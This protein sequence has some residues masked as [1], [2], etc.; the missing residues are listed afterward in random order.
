MPSK[1]L[2]KHL[3]TQVVFFT[4]SSNTHWFNTHPEELC[5]CHRDNDSICCPVFAAFCELCL[6]RH[7]SSPL[8][9]L[10]FN[11][12]KLSCLWVIEPEK[13]LVSQA[14]SCWLF[15]PRADA[16]IA[17]RTALTDSEKN[18][19]ISAE[20][21]LMK[22]APKLNVT[23]SQNL[24]DDF[25][26]THIVQANV[27]HNSGPFLPWHRLYSRAPHHSLPILANPGCCSARA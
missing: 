2:I 9:G 14:L 26:Y 7:R 1:D 5:S 18:A 20:L 4:D 17:P 27:I 23:G 8:A 19:Y 6:S 12:R 11:R 21:C 3:A 13:V 25:M 24:W 15:S 16:D 10:I 22:A